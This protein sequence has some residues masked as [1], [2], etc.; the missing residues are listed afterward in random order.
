MSNHT[1]E[2]WQVHHDIDAGEWPMPDVFAA[3]QEWGNVPWPEMFRSFN[4]G[5]GMILVLSEAEAAK[6]Q[7]ALALKNEPCYQ[8]GKV[9]AGNREVVLKGGVFGE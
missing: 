5:I 6:V 3:L 9:V 4:M 1:P 7:K 8:I 2:P